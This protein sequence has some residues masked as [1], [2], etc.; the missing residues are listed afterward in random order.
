[1]NVK[2]NRQTGFRFYI[3]RGTL[4]PKMRAEIYFLFT[5]FLNGKIIMKC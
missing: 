5:L 1:M 4:K 3:Y 2:S